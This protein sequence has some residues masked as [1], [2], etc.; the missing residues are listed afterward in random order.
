MPYADKITGHHQCEFLPNMS[1]TDQIFYICQ[2]LEKDFKKAY[3][4]VR[5]EIYNILIQFGT[6]R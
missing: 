2:I 5:R 1:M 4:S 3:D 6:P